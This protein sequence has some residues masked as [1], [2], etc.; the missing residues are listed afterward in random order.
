MSGARRIALAAG[1]TCAAMLAAAFFFQHV[2]G[3][4]PCPLCIWQRWPHLAGA[5]LGLAAA[6]LGPGRAAWG[7]MALGA[8]AMLAGAGIAGFHVGVEQGWW[9]SPVCAPAAPDPASLS[10]SEFLDALRAQTDI[11][12]CD[13]VA[14]S[15]FGVSMAGWNGLASLA[16]A[17]LFGWGARLRR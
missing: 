1:L 6:A 8:L 16:L 14:W 12:A 4:A 3:L 10:P 2:V 15:L 5:A 11:V 7:A 13:E 9:D 17:A